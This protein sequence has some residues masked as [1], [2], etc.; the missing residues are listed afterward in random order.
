LH[1]AI[2]KCFDQIG[3]GYFFERHDISLFP[4]T[5]STVALRFPVFRTGTVKF[6][7]Q[8]QCHRYRWLVEWLLC[9]AYL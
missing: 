8:Q 7:F 5:A 9:T 3:R 2:F 1:T 6:V 4:A